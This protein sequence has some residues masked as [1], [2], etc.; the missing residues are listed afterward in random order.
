MSRVNKD[1]PPMI[2]SNACY[3]HAWSLLNQL[4]DNV[5]NWLTFH[6]F[7]TTCIVDIME[8]NTAGV[9]RL[10]MPCMQVISVTT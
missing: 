2:H 6:M 7:F 5:V 3:T 9:V 10:E 8:D 4:Y 1:I